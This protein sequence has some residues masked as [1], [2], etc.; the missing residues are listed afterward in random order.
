MY[1]LY[2][3]GNSIFVLCIFVLDYYYHRI[4]IQQEIMLKKLRRDWIT[5]KLTYAVYSNF[6]HEK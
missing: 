2:I 3:E 6:I 1:E 5:L 4:S